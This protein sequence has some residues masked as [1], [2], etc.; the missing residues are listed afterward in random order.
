M[1]SLYVVHVNGLVIENTSLII[2]DNNWLVCVVTVQVDED[3]SPSRPR[4]NVTWMK[5][6]EVIVT[7][8][9]RKYRHYRKKKILEIFD[10][11]YT[12]QGLYECGYSREDTQRGLAELWSK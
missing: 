12:D 5:D 8:H 9:N 6:G 1:N 11:T 3:S 2:T 10:L 7:E 4:S